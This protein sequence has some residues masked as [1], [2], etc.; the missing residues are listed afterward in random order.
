MFW[1]NSSHAGQDVLFS[2]VTQF[3][4]KFPD[5]Y[6]PPSVHCLIWS[7]MF[8]TLKHPPYLYLKYGKHVSTLSLLFV[9]NYVPNFETCWKRK[10]SNEHITLFVPVCDNVGCVVT[11]V[12]VAYHCKEHDSLLIVV[13]DSTY[14]LLQILWGVSW[15]LIYSVIFSYS[16][17]NQLFSLLFALCCCVCR[18]QAAVTTAWSEL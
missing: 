12:H 8:L 11:A 1:W 10:K 17:N 2:K 9:N 18:L 15:Q 3:F 14:F 5:F 16:L 4:C 7:V 13:L 6:R